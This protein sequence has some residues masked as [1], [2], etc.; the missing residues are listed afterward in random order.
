MAV[1]DALRKDVVSSGPRRRPL[2][3]LLWAVPVGLLLGIV[4]GAAGFFAWCGTEQCAE[5]DARQ[6]VVDSVVAF[7]AAGIGGALGGLIVVTATPGARVRTRLA[8]GT[9]VFAVVMLLAVWYFR[10]FTA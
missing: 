1:V 4:V 5:T 3:H 6:Y 10:R 2:L 9:G 7:A 8:A